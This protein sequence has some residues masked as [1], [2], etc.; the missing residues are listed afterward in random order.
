MGDY[1]AIAEAGQAVVNVIWAAISADPQLTALIDNENLIS[2]ESP[3]EHIDNQDTALLSV[4]LYRIDQEPYLR[5]TRPPEGPGGTRAG[6]PLSLNLYYLITPMLTDARDRHVV[7]GKIMQTLY[8]HP[9]LQ[10]PDTTGSLA[11]VGD[12]LRVVLNPVPINEIALIWQALEIPYM[13][14]VPYVVRIALLQADDIDAGARVVSVS[15]RY[16]AVASAAAGGG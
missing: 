11:A 16:G 9:T 7:L 4:Y 13:L 12:E 14:C 1:T 10:A 2:L 3:A 5:N 15:R 8:A 6:V